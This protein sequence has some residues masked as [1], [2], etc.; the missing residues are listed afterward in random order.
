MM[1]M[2]QSLL[3]DRFKLKVRH[4]IREGRVYALVIAKG[5][6]K[7]LH[8]KSPV[9]DR[10][11]TDRNSTPLPPEGPTFSAGL[12]CYQDYLSMDQLA[13]WLT[14]SLRVG[15]PVIDQTELKGSY[16]IKL[17]WAPEELQADVGISPGLESSGPS[18]FGALQQQLG[19]KL[20]PT[21][22]PVEVF[23]VDHVEKPSE[24]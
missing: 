2:F 1:S 11:A 18:I 14:R 3:V 9:D 17:Q 13:D 10:T 7:F 5:G 15:R 21:R 6:P 8:T 23:I 12:W 22:G 24:N 20:E 16:Y 4:E 19:L